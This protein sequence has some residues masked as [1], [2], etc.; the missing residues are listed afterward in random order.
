MTN[1]LNKIMHNGDE[2]LIPQ[3]SVVR[4]TLASADWSND[5]QTVTVAWVTADNTIV[6]SPVPTSMSDYTS[7]GIIYT[8]QGTDSLT[9]ECTTTPSNDIDVN[10]VIFK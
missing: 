8:A 6:V 10:V 4:V 9:F 2:Y 5:E 1:T 3:Y 7:G